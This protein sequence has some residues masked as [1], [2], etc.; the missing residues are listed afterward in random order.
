MSRL[1]ATAALAACVSGGGL[2]AAQDEGPNLGGSY[3]FAS[4]DPEAVVATS[5]DGAELTQRD[6]DTVGGMM[7][8]A[9]GTQLTE[10]EKRV[11]RESV[12]AFWR[13]TPPEGVPQFRGAFRE[14]PA[15]IVALPAEQREPMRHAVAQVFLGM[16]DAF[17]DDPLSKVARAV[18]SAS[19][20]VLAGAGTPYELTQQDVDALLEYICFQN[21]MMTG[22]V[23]VVTPEQRETFTADVIA[24]FEGGS[25]EEQAELAQ[26]DMLWGQLRAAW[27][28]A[29]AAQQQNLLQQQIR[30]WQQA[31]QQQGIYDPAAG[32]WGAAQPRGGW[33]L[34]QDARERRLNA[35]TM[36]DILKM[37]HNTSMAIIG[38]MG[39]GGGLDVFDSSGNW[40]YNR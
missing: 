6:V 31:Y 25:E 38:N 14:L 13:A 28:A 27:A 10:G 26:F 36:S 32:G 22:Q 30:Q 18:S 2:A 23:V 1:V 3:S 9:F 21:R 16:I 4:A 11:V 17:P 37:K 29:E 39:G 7:A 5:Q 20:H 8:W 40:L 35:E 24:R 34:M 15:Q 33:E 12:V 19:G